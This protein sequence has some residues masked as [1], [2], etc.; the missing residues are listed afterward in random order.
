MDKIKVQT[1]QQYVF[2]DMNGERHTWICTPPYS[3]QA[4]S[5]HPNCTKFA[6]VECRRCTTTLCELID[7][8]SPNRLVQVNPDS[9][10]FPCIPGHNHEWKKPGYPTRL[11]CSWWHFCLNHG[12]I[13]CVNCSVELCSTHMT[14]FKI[15]LPRETVCADKMEETIVAPKPSPPEPE[16]KPSVRGFPA[17]RSCKDRSWHEFRP[18]ARGSLVECTHGAL[19][20]MTAVTICVRCGYGVCAQ[21]ITNPEDTMDLANDPTSPVPP[22]A[23][24][25]PGCGQTMWP[26]RPSKPHD[27][28]FGPSGMILNCTDGDANCD[29]RAVVYCTECLRGRCRVCMDDYPDTKALFNWNLFPNSCKEGTQHIWT[30]QP[31]SMRLCCTLHEQCTNPALRI[32]SVCGA[33]MCQNPPPSSEKSENVPVPSS[34]TARTLRSYFMADDHEHNWKQ[35][36]DGLPLYCTWDGQCGQRGEVICQHCPKS[37]CREH[38]NRLRPDLKSLLENPTKKTKKKKKTFIGQYKSPWIEENFPDSMPKLVDK[39]PLIDRPSEQNPTP[40]P[41]YILVGPPKSP[42]AVIQPYV[43]HNEI[44]D[45][46]L[47]AHLWEHGMEVDQI[48]PRRDCS[49]A[50]THFCRECMRIVCNKCRKKDRQNP[51]LCLTRWAGHLWREKTSPS[52][53]VEFCHVYQCKRRSVYICTDC[54]IGQCQECRT[55]VYPCRPSTQPSGSIT[56]DAGYLKS[57][58]HHGLVE[59]KVSKPAEQLPNGGYKVVIPTITGKTVE[60]KLPKHDYVEA[61]SQTEYCSMPHCNQDRSA[62]NFN[63]SCAAYKCRHCDTKVCETC[64]KGA[65]GWFFNPDFCYQ[66]CQPN[67]HAHEWGPKEWRIL[68]QIE[69]NPCASHDCPNVGKTSLHVS[70]CASCHRVMCS[71]CLTKWEGLRRAAPPPLADDLVPDIPDNIQKHSYRPFELGIE[72]ICAAPDCAQSR[73]YN[74]S[75][76]CENCG[77]KQC[78]A[79][80]KRAN[81]DI[82]NLDYCPRRCQGGC[83]IHKWT[84]RTWA[85][86]KKPGLSVCHNRDCFNDSDTHKDVYQCEYCNHPLCVECHAVWESQ[87]FTP[88]DQCP[89]PEPGP[90]RAERKR[91]Q[92]IQHAL[93][94][95]NK[96]K[97]RYSR[98]PPVHTEEEKKK[99]ELAYLESVRQTQV[100][101]EKQKAGFQRMMRAK[102]DMDELRDRRRRDPDL[103]GLGSICVEQED[104]RKNTL[105]HFRDLDY[106]NRLRELFEQETA[107]ESPKSELPTPEPTKLTKSAPPSSVVEDLDQEDDDTCVVCL[108]RVRNIA[109]SPCGHFVLCN[110]CTGDI[111]ICPICR[112][113]IASTLRIFK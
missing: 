50:A 29:L 54:K 62:R 47:R 52:T 3:E 102:H 56:S 57:S 34:L 70:T 89:D 92:A 106:Q 35:Y 46:T 100:R 37:I 41:N 28:K 39:P 67:I 111:K 74:E 108:E 63:N 69:L 80:A 81:T 42:S 104:H 58:L 94:L 99:A 13:V 90:D 26:N 107:P 112:G 51:L 101:E 21:H 59:T 85:S 31:A 10:G 83:I 60:L 76:T 53:D 11:N 73:G 18:C 2:C 87:C 20:V 12:T 32:C 113:P 109:I 16:V 15:V 77:S 71:T 24:R 97:S 40:H 8:P 4:C 6:V 86:V 44:C 33:G 105:Q 68:E 78:T 72:S 103:I 66:R 82:I 91:R 9:P 75:F 5:S 110:I 55:R 98:G 45:R 88:Y 19:C 17:V 36:V 1:P 79:C 65:L 23:K 61:R 93:L 22:S 38:V 43:V 25:L 95:T 64:P 49:R 84:L 96:V 48:C 7:G 27:W 30:K 14:T